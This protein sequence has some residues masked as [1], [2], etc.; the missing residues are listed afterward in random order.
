MGRD[1]GGLNRGELVQVRRDIGFIFQAHNLFESLTAYQNVKM[2]L[3]LKAR[4]GRA[5]HDRAVEILGALGLGDR[6]SYKP[7]SLSGGQRQRV[8]IARALANRPRLVLA[9]EPTAALDEKSGRNV[10]NLLQKLAREERTTSLIVTHDNRILDVADRIITLVDGRIKSNIL[11]KESVAICLFLAKWP[12]FAG[13]TPDALS[14]VAEKMVKEKHPAGSVIIRQGEEGDKFYLIRSGR[15]DVIADDDR[16]TRKVLA[17]MGEGEI[18]GEMALL[19]GEPRRATV[20]ALEN[21]ET[22]TLAKADFQAALN[23]SASF[24]EQLYKVYFQRQ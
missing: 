1:L 17:T 23:A 16:P 12:P 10:V 9:D 3:Q 4:D 20:K 19:T 6:L 13:L 5:M 21:L 8:A 15:V 24:K 7:D 18:F 11:A 2:A 22:Y 14:K